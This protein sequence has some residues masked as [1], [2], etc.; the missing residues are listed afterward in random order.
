MEYSAWYHH[1]G[2]RADYDPMILMLREQ[3]RIWLEDMARNLPS[4]VDIQDDE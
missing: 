1:L 2:H 3:Q 4:F